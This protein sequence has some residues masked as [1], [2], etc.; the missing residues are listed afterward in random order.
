MQMSCRQIGTRPSTTTM[1]TTMTTLSPWWRHQMEAFS[2]LLTLCVGNSPGT[3][4][5]PTQTPVSQ[6]FDVFFDMR[7]NKRLRKQSWGWWFE[8][9]SRPLKRHCNVWVILRDTGIRTPPLNKQSREVGR[10][11]AY[12]FILLWVGPSSHSGNTSCCREPLLRAHI[13]HEA[14]LFV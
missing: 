4:E 5:F 13:W 10:S 9:P 8:T 14:A 12:C 2:A 7:P 3:G 6:N 1:L 11:P